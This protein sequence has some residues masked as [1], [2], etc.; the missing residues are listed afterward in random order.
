MAR[1]IIIQIPMY[2]IEDSDLDTADLEQ[3]FKLIGHPEKTKIVSYTFDPNTFHKNIRISNKYFKNIPITELTPAIRVEINE[4]TGDFYLLDG[5]S[6][7]WDES[8]LDKDLMYDVNNGL[9]INKI[10]IIE[11]T[12]DCIKD[13]EYKKPADIAKNCQHFYTKYLSKMICMHC[14][15]NQ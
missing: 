4:N 14:G 13:N 1:E 10:P 7:D 3:I 11:K 15:E 6:F 12:M 5:G 9:I 8:E 2:I